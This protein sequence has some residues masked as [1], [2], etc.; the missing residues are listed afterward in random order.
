MA[1]MKRIWI[2]LGIGGV[3]VS[4]LTYFGSQSWSGATVFHLL[5]PGILIS[6]MF[7]MS[8]PTSLL[9]MG[10]VNVM[11][12]SGV[13]YGLLALFGIARSPAKSH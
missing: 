12:Y 10:A 5:F 11:V 6:M 7:A 2:A 8:G 1:G 9:V 13:A 4:L 3:L